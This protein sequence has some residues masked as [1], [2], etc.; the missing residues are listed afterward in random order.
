MFFQNRYFESSQPHVLRSAHCWSCN[1]CIIRR[2]HHCIFVGRC[3]GQAN[4]RFFFSLS[5]YL[6]IGVIYCNFLNFDYTFE[7]LGGFT[8]K[9]VFTMAL[10]L[11]SW[12]LGFSGA[13]G[14]LVSLVAA[15]C[16]MSMFFL[17]FLTG[18]HSSNII[19]NQTSPE[20]TCNDFTYQLPS[21]DKNLQ[22][23]LGPNYL[24]ACLLPSFTYPQPSGFEFKSA[25]VK[26]L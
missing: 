6:T 7:V 15:I 4:L 16:L 20:R 17:F 10:P 18:Y 25:S 9:A 24:Q 1:L 3:I 21:W 22:A 23:T 5:I 8:W 19:R 2:D 13:M 12:G 11:F 14:F 26:H